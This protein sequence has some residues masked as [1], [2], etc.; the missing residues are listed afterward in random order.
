MTNDQYEGEFNE[1]FAKLFPRETNEK[2]KIIDE[3]TVDPH[4]LKILFENED[5]YKETQIASR[6][7]QLTDTPYAPNNINFN[8]IIK[9][10]IDN[11][12]I[13]NLVGI[14]PMRAPVDSVF[15]L[16]YKDD[17]GGEK[18]PTIVGTAIEASSRTLES[19]LTIEAV[20]DLNAQ[21]G[22][23]FESEIYSIFGKKIASE[24]CQEV[25]GDLVRS[26]HQETVG[27]EVSDMSNVVY[28]INRAA[29]EIARRTRRGRGN[30]I[31]VGPSILA[32]LIPHQGDFFRKDCKM[33]LDGS[34]L[35]HVGTLE[36]KY[37]V[38]YD[39]H[40]T[41]QKVL[42]GYKGNSNEIDCGYVLCPYVMLLTSSNT[43]HPK[44]LQPVV[45]FVAR[46]GKLN[47]RSEAE[48]NTTDENGNEIIMLMS[49]PNDYYTTITFNKMPPEA[50]KADLTTVTDFLDELEP[51]NED[52]N[53]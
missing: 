12:G 13:H 24:F 37:Q 6:T 35:R 11:W 33:R 31:V 45:N 15:R 14:Q 8:A 42:I 27:G 53:K 26:S 46:Y 17:D 16:V 30:W 1:A 10:V 47:F 39:P 18:G 32:Q 4:Y 38:F 19:R 5:R 50:S 44:T 2:Q 20:Q 52:K 29:N 40:M 34:A 36:E 41:A 22:C 3:D 49:G 7:G 51:T 23:D 25:V 21:H 28:A 9:Q 43:I 48:S